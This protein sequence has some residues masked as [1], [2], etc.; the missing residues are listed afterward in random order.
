MGVTSRTQIPQEVNNFYSRTLLERA[1]PTFLHQHFAQVRDIISHGGTNVIKFRRYNNLAAATTPLT[2]GVTPVGSSM[3]SVEI[4]ATV[5]QYGDYVTFTD[6]VQYETPDAV[7]TEYAGEL[8]DQTADTYDQICRDILAAGTS[9]YY[10][11]AAVAR[12]GVAAGDLITKTLIQKVVRGLK[13]NNAMKI[14]SMVSAGPN[15]AT[16]PLNECFVGIAHPNVAYTLNT[17]D[18]WIPVEKYSAQKNIM[19]GEI[20][21]I[22]QV[23][24][25]ET[26]NAKVFTGEGAAGID[27]YATIILAKNAYGI[28]RITGQTLEN[29][30]TPPGGP[31]DPLRQRQSSGW[32]GTFTAKILNNNFLT[33]IE[34]AVA[35]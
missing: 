23:R 35:A 21:S 27:V 7:L 30:V 3:S 26:T 10:G 19:P 33:R 9:V 18:G 34:T 31:S 8:G 5:S 16:V 20:G 25:I 32:K 6:V 4:T 14:T 29:I 15:I 13:N 28:S 17:L 24:F 2:E 22:E 12:I 1:V 11:G